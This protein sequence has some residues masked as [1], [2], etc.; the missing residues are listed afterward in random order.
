MGKTFDFNRYA[1]DANIIKLYEGDWQ[2]LW[3]TNFY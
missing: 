1:Y 2:A 3:N